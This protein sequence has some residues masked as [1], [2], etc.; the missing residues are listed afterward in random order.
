[1]VVLVVVVVCVAVA[2]L[3]L[4]AGLRGRVRGAGNERERERETGIHRPH[5]NVY[6]YIHKSGPGQQRAA[7]SKTAKCGNVAEKVRCFT[8]FSLFSFVSFLAF[9]ETKLKPTEE[10]EVCC[11]LYPSYE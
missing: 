10:A 2:Y 5:K 11:F 4:R 6:K 7:T 1:M 9:H 3:M 8:F